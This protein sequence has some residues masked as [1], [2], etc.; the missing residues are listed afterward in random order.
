MNIDAMEYTS[1]STAEYQNVSEKVN[2]S[3]PTAPAK[4]MEIS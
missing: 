1:P 3:A 4:R 2:A